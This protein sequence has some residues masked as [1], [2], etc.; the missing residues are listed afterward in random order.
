[1]RLG[2]K[3]ALIGDRIVPGDV[4][5]EDGRISA[6]GLSPAGKAGTAVPGFVDLQVNGF[7]GVDFV[8]AG[9]VGYQTAG[10]ALAATGVTS[11]Q[12]T[13]ITSPLDSY[14]AALEAAARAQ[15]EPGPRVL[16]VHLEGPFISPEWVGAHNPAHVLDP[17]PELAVRLIESGPVSH[18]TLAPERP[19]A[20]ELIALLMQ[21][22]ITV[23]CGHSDADASRAHDAFDAGSRVLT[24]IYNAHR[25]WRPRDPGLAGAALVRDSVTVTAIVD[26]VHLAPETAAAT[27]R[28]TRGRFALITDAIEAAGLGDGTYAL[29]DRRVTVRAGEVRL[30]NGRLAGSVLT[31]DGALRNLVGLG[32]SLAEAVHAAARAPA[33][34][35][36]RRDLGLLEEGATA[37]VVVLD[38]RLQVTRTL[39]GGR[40]LWASF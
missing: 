26:N 35:A 11:Y 37:D 25:R 13:L 30:E 36:G 8:V 7:S 2:A 14:P 27:F 31:M 18:M 17:D 23:A 38:D 6:A 21:R 15:G 32:A 10:L 4:Q 39:V 9:E 12:P 3:E 33:L 1:M 19:G 28:A 34:A 16:G 5:V 40:E 20:L 29:G 22:N 24:H